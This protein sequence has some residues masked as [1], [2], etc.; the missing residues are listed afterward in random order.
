MSTEIIS[1]ELRHLGLRHD[2]VSSD[3]SSGASSSIDRVPHSQGSSS[4]RIDHDGSKDI[5]LHLSDQLPWSVVITL[6]LLIKGVTGE[7]GVS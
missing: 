2:S 1:T 7:P 6:A 5:F 4:D 3:A